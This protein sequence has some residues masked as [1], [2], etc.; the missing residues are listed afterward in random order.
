[1]IGGEIHKGPMSAMSNS[2]GKA[3]CETKLTESAVRVRLVG[4]NP[5]PQVEG[6]EPLPGR[7]NYLI[8]GS[9][10]LASRH[11]DLRARDDFMTCIRASTSSI[12]ES[13]IRLN[14]ISSRRRVR[15][16]RRS[17]FAIEGRAKTTRTRTAIWLILTASGV[18]MIAK[19][20]NYQHDADGS[21][22]PVEG[23]FMLAKD[24]TIVAGIPRRE[25]SAFS[26]RV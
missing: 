20:Q 7:V 17:K 15:T 11:P 2:A 8:G 13:A 24:G 16:L 23:G 25:R 5:H 19:P 14:M 12:T 3:R 1:M 4:A 10:E 26:L 9:K 21:R 18:I 6:L 22:T